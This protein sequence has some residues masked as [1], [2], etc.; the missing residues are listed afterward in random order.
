MRSSKR[1]GAR[2]GLAVAAGLTVVVSTGPAHGAPA[3][4]SKQPPPPA[5]GW[6][7]DRV[8]FEALDA[9]TPLTAEGSGDYRGAIEVAPSA[10]GVATINDVSL[11]DYLRGVSEV[12]PTWPAEALKAQAIAARSF[13]LH[14]VAS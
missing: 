2:S 6:V 7:V 8:R 3:P 13:A 4:G 9:A 14:E 12:P 5:R 10:G 1:W 11:D